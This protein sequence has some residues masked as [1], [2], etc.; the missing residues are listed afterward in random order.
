MERRK[1][2]VGALMQGTPRPHYLCGTGIYESEGNLHTLSTKLNFLSEGNPSIEDRTE[3][4]MSAPHVNAGDCCFALWNAA[5]VIAELNGYKNRTLRKQIIINPKRPIPPNTEIDLV[6]KV[7][8]GKDL[9]MKGKRYS[10][11]T[12]SGSF[13]L[14]GKELITI[15]AEY[16]AER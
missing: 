11:G 2:D 5:H 7:K 13:S 4:Y 15:S 1:I 14:N 16:C 9:E 10:L 8:D 3:K 6:A 12:I